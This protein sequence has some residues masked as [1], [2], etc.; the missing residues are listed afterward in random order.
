[1]S[2]ELFIQNAFDKRGILSKNTVCAP[3]LCGPYARLYPIK[4]QFF[5]LKVGQK[6]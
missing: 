2:F 5:G 6:F 3:S 4:P 1:M